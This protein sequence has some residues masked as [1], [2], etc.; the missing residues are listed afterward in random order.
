MKLTPR[1]IEI[2]EELLNTCYRIEIVKTKD[3][4]RIFEIKRTEAK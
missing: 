1:Q 2:I 3:G 4:I